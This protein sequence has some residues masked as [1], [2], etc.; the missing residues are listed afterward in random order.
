MHKA[1]LLGCGEP[2]ILEVFKNTLPTRLYWV[3]FPIEDLKQAVQT[4]RRILMKEK[5]DRQLVGQSSSTPFLSIKD[6]YVC[7]K[8]TFDTKDS[9]EAKID[10]LMTMMSRLSDQDDEQH[11]QFKPKV[12]QGKRRGQ[13][14]NFYN[15]HNHDEKMIRIDE[16][17]TV[18]ID[19]FHLVVGYNVDEITELDQDISRTIEMTL[20]KVISG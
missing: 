16:D 18:E 6:S 7:K 14:R 5:I 10:R 3:I 13:I 4:A 15:K 17:Q 19:F 2:H 8:A 11:K 20:D 9:L 1:A 12:Y